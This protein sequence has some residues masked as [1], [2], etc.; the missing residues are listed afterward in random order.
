MTALRRGMQHGRAMGVGGPE[1]A[2]GLEKNVT[3]QNGETR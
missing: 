2:G 3:D 1:Q